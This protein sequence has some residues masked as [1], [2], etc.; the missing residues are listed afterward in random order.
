[1]AFKKIKTIS[2][3]FNSN[4]INNPSSLALKYKKINHNYV[5]D[6]SFLLSNNYGL[7]RQHNLLS[8]KA[9]LQ[10]NNT[11]LDSNSF[12]QFLVNQQSSE[13]IGLEN[14]DF[15]NNLLNL[16]QTSNSSTLNTSLT[17]NQLNTTTSVMD[18]N[19]TLF[20]NYPQLLTMVN[21][22]SDKAFLNYPLRKIFNENLLSSNLRNKGFLNANFNFN[23][24]SVIPFSNTSLTNQHQTFKTLTN[25]SS[26]QNFLPSDQNLRQYENLEV[27]K[28]NF[29]L[30]G[31]QF[32]D[33]SMYATNPLTSYFNIK[34][35][36]INSNVFYKLSS[37]R[38]NFQLPYTPIFDTNNAFLKSLDYDYSNTMSDEITTST[39]GF[40]HSYKT[41]K[42]N[43]ISILKGKRDGAPDFLNTTY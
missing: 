38:V 8:L 29:N 35:S 36:F 13:N 28:T 16:S 30:E 33:S 12:N 11:F 19:K 9:N 17:L 39:Q 3:T 1:M 10:K 31:R 21:N 24:T 34:S 20:Q 2:K 27:N 26:N 15:Y 18:Y 4:L 5:N 7:N 43:N 6:N 40:T 22:N 14:L 32:F 25:L 42:T 23:N 41:N 37:N